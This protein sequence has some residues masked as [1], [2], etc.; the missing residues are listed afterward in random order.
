MTQKPCPHFNR[1]SSLSIVLPAY[2]EE[3]SIVAMVEDV[4]KSVHTLVNNYEVIV[5]DDGSR[6]QTASLVSLQCAQYHQVRLLTHAK[7]QGYGAAL[8]TGLMN[9]RNEWV[10]FTDSDR[11]FDLSELENLL[12]CSDG[13]GIVAGYRAPRRDSFLR[14]L[15]GWGWSGLVTLMFGYTVRDID[16]AFKLIRQ[17]IIAEVGPQIISRGATF[18]AELLVR[19]KRSGQRLIEVPLRGHRPR[20]IGVATGNRPDVIFR[21]FRELLWLR[22]IM[23]RE[24]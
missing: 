24:A 4:V 22:Y 15:F 13:A 12:F 18:S 5:V 1:L 19:A 21:A 9:A 17:S 16:C 8:L 10:F 14:K 11:Q 6:D 23:W 2:N 20:E 7:N 3:L